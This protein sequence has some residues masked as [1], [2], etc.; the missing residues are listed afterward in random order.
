MENSANV[1]KNYLEN[2]GNA[3]GLSILVIFTD[4]S[5]PVGRGIGPALEAKDVL[6]VLQRDKNAPEDLRNK[7]LL[8][9]ERMLEFSPQV[10]PGSGLKPATT[11]LDS[12]QALKKFQAICEA[13][14][15]M[16]TPPT[17]RFTHHIIAKSE[18]KVVAIDNRRLSRIAKLA[19]APNSK[20]AG[21]ELFALLNTVIKK[22]Q[23][24]CWWMTLY[25]V[26]RRCMRLFFI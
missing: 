2:I 26:A 13:Q 20:V 5:Q 9:A 24:L 7:A 3:L 25:R 4:D 23:P 17:A 22:G 15:G 18:G 16:F 10:Q 12:R 1:L 6:A 14:G 21:V 8:L 11:I 19:G